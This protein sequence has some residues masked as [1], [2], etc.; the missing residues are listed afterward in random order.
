MKN[1]TLATANDMLADAPVRV[2]GILPA[3]D[4]DMAAVNALAGTELSAY[5]IYEKPL[6]TDDPPLSSYSCEV[7]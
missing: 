2:A 6:W 7:S 3:T 1:R 4:A 5:A